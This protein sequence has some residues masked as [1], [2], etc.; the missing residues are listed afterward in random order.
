MDGGGG[1]SDA[2][3]GYDDRD[4]NGRCKFDEESFRL[5]GISDHAS[6]SAGIVGLFP[7]KHYIGTTVLPLLS[8]EGPLNPQSVVDAVGDWEGPQLV[9][10]I[11][12]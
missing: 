4:G 2:R 9:D 6:E 7:K 1:D 12:I 11:H 10:A 8:Q 3:E 5:V